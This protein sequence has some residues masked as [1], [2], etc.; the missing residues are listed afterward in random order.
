MSFE[1]IEQTLAEQGDM[2]HHQW[3][4]HMLT[5]ILFGMWRDYREIHGATS[6]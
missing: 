2:K 5:H 6:K 3:Y 4:F 1:E